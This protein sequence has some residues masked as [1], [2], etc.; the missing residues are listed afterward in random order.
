[1]ICRRCLLAA[2]RPQKPSLSS[3]RSS[4]RFSTANTLRDATP[5]S[6][7]TATQSVPSRTPPAATSTSAAQP[8]SAPITPAASPQL[9]KEAAEKKTTPLVRSAV[10]AG[11]PLK[12]LNFLKDKTDPVAMADEEYPEWLWSILDRQ[13]KKGEG[14]AAG[15]L[16]SKSK[17]QRRVAAKRLRKEHLANPELLGPKIPVYEQTLDLPASDGTLDGSVKASDARDGLTKAMRGKRRA[18][19]KEKNFLKAMG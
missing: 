5:I 2:S 7:N 16:F 15:D 9:K 8:F 14:A 3:L 1:M 10:P 12:G 11:T 13:E 18:D 17:K 6:A 4:H 19:I